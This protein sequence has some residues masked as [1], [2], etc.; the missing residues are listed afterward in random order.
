[1]NVSIRQLK[2]FVQASQSGSFSAAA[3]VLGMTQPALSQLI[4]QMEDTLGLALFHRTTRRMALTV[5]GQEMLGK[6]KRTLHQL[7]DFKRHADDL[8][9]GRQG[10]LTLG[11]IASVA[12]S[13]LPQALV[14][15]A[16][17]CPGV[18][19][20][21]QEEPAALLL[22]RVRHGELELG[23]GLY[24]T[25]HD[26][27]VFEPLGRDQMVAVMHAGH[28]LAQRAHVGWDDL[29][30]HKLV[31][32]SR[33]SGVRIYAERA[34]EAAGVLLQPSYQ[35]GSLTTGMALVRCG[36][37][38]AVMPALSL[39]S[40]N[41]DNVV[42]RPMAQPGVWREIGLIQRQGWPLSPAA[43]VFAHL[44]RQLTWPANLPADPAPWPR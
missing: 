20:L 5:A 32:A 2:A 42:V 14:G 7:D 4:R 24:P 10:T 18:S 16:A 36:L 40:L 34:A 21:F 29:R 19:L 22:E 27:L 3:Q 44:A 30:Q 1:M 9:A 6:A 15:F 33:Q 12:C 41:L 13:L 25:A 37:G 23:W 17:A 39:G 8:H 11:V 43:E 38:C 28:A 31:S 26:E 35:T